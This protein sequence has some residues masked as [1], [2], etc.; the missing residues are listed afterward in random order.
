VNQLGGYMQDTGRSAEEVAIDLTALL[1]KPI[2]PASVRLWSSRQKPPKAWADALNLP[3]STIP[4]DHADSFE[5]GPDT[6]AAEGL[7]P[8][9]GGREEG[10]PPTPPPGARVTARPPAAL[11][12]AAAKERIAM[13][14][15]AIGAGATLVTHNHGYEAVADH[16][17]PGLADAWIKAA[18]TNATVAKI[19]RFMDQGGPVGELVVGYVILI[20]GF[21]YVSGRGPQLDFIFGKFAGHRA[22]AVA[23]AVA[24][25]AEAHLNGSGQ[26]P[27]QGVVGEPAV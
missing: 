16:Y 13:A 19:V 20:L 18:E 17:A 26:T 21:A 22:A 10:A 11:P 9:R 25:E 6:D 8:G 5:L 2:S 12:T 14:H 3:E 4:D 24:A 23:A 7:D 1:G 15:T 27:P